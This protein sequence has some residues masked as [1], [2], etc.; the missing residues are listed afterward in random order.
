MAYDNTKLNIAIDKWLKKNCAMQ[1]GETYAGTLLDDFEEF[2][3]NKQL[4]KRS[5]GRVVFGK[6]LAERKLEKR[7]KNG[8]IFWSGIVLKK[9]RQTIPRLHTATIHRMEEQ[10]IRRD[11]KESLRLKQLEAARETTEEKRDRLKKFKAEN[12]ATTKKRALKA[13]E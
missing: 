4:L 1:M 7:R 2:C 5:P 9:D 8:L 13:G 6:M 12:R 3:A 10:Q 11:E